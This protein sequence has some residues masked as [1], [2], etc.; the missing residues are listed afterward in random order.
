[1][2]E[3]KHSVRPFM[4]PSA[5]HPIPAKPAAGTLLHARYL[6][7]LGQT[8]TIRAADSGTDIPLLHSWHN[9]PRV[10]AFWN[11]A[12]DEA[13][14]LAYLTS[15]TS[16]A[17]SIP[18]IGSLD[19]VPFL[20]LEVY[21][22]AH[23]LLGRHLAAQPYDRG[24]H[25]LVGNERLRGAH[26]AKEWIAAVLDW[27][28]EDCKETKRVLV[29]PRIDNGAIIGYCCNAG[30]TF[31]GSLRLPHKTSAILMTTRSEWEQRRRRKNLRSFM[32]RL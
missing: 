16:S 23:D 7:V 22:V 3:T 31:L 4:N 25:A 15:V 24:F 18:C 9:Q 27:A 8:L 19:G 14:Q 17:H 30:A 2:L 13:H 5:F 11:E 29:E 26:R 6:S 1:M 32:A 10:N 21:W 20:Y 28:F 12:G